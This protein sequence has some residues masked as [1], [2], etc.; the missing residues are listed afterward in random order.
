MSRAEMHGTGMKKILFLVIYV[1]F[2][3]F[4]YCKCLHCKGQKSF[5]E[6]VNSSKEKKCTLLL[7]GIIQ[8]CHVVDRSLPV[9]LLL[10]F[11]LPLQ[12]V[13]EH[14]TPD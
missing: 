3:N 1:L 11:T 6:C 10:S 7:I 9:S 14:T 5:I 13:G 2:S 12:M 4:S 8:F